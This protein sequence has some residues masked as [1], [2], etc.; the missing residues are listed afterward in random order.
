MYPGPSH[1]GSA[2]APP[3]PAVGGGGWGERAASLYPDRL[4]DQGADGADGEA[5]GAADE[6]DGLT[7][8]VVRVLGD[9]V[10]AAGQ[11][12]GVPRAPVD[13]QLEVLAQLVQAP[14]QVVDLLDLHAG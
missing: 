14:G 12:E 3:P 13:L 9:V 8:G 2:E 10:A 5:E 6:E 1:P 4:A 7:E 11:G